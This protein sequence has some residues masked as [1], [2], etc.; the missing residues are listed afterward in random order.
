[1]RI[2]TVIAVILGLVLEF[3]LLFRFFIYPS[4]SGTMG[5]QPRAV[6]LLVV[7]MAILWFLAVV[8]VVPLPLI[9]IVCFALAGV[10]ALGGSLLLGKLGGWVER[11]LALVLLSVLAW[12][13]RY[14]SG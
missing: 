12:R 11:S 5:Q 13:E 14:G 9:S 4:V 8:F 6:L 7:M 3:A 2:A 10:V 1:M